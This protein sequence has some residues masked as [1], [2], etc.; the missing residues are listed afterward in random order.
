MAFY[1]GKLYAIAKNDENLLIVNISQDPIT[2][3]PQVSRIVPVI[4]AGDPFHTNT[5]SM[6]K[7]KLYLV[8]SCDALLMVRRK[9]FCRMAA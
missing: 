3:D 7:K 6:V 1:Q 8:E 4:T 9:V 5:N 2:G